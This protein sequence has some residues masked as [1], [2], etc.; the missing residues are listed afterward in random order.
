MSYLSYVGRRLLG[1]EQYAEVKGQVQS[2][3]ASALVAALPKGEG[4]E[5][6]KAIV[7]HRVTL[8]DGQKFA[9]GA[10]VFLIAFYYYWRKG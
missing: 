1:N 10:A 2:S 4:G 5:A 8:S 6:P 3:A 7:D 9:I